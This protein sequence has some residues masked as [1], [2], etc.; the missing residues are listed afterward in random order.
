M[1]FRH[2]GA[3]SPV[4]KHRDGH[5]TGGLGVEPKA[6]WEVQALLMQEVVWEQ[7]WA[8]YNAGTTPA[9]ELFDKYNQLET[10]IYRFRT[11]N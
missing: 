7:I 10:Q 8:A 2:C 11:Q 9:R 4:I 3:G 6:D 1:K 5:T